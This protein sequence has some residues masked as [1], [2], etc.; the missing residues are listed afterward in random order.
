MIL[1][2]ACSFADPDGGRAAPV[3]FG[4][5]ASTPASAAPSAAFPPGSALDAAPPTAT[6]GAAPTAAFPKDLPLPTDVI[7]TLGADG[8]G[9]AM[10]AGRSS[11]TPEEL[12]EQITAA[13]GPPW[14]AAAREKLAAYWVIAYRDGDRGVIF[15]VYPPE[16]DGTRVIVLAR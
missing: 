4:S 6:F 10:M 2:F 14:T 3:G 5:P 11:H 15:Q 7:W 9:G 8:D 1:V 13:V 16:A 12:V